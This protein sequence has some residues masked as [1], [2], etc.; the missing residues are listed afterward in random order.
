MTIHEMVESQLRQRGIRDE[1]VLAA[2]ERVPRHL[3]VPETLRD[4]AY[5]DG[6]LPIGFKQ[7][8]SQPYIVAFMTELL[9]L[10]PHNKVLEIGTGSGYQTAILAE[11]SDQIYSIESVEPL[12]HA[13]QQRL[14]DLGYREDRIHLKQA[15]GSHGWLEEA[16]FDKI[17]VTAAAERIPE[18][19]I[20]QLE[21]KGRIVIPVAVGQDDQR[22]VVGE[23]VDGNF[24]T[25][26]NISV[27]FVPLVESGS[28]IKGKEKN[29]EEKS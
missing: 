27:R 25:R 2:M 28:H 29:N 13:A 16:P 18:A 20:G 3:F 17:L 1:R 9:E 19:L 26:S 15:D 12:Y 5:L 6:P 7:T 23:I 10:H 21:P 4:S 22:L 24:R 14:R 8:I 11:L